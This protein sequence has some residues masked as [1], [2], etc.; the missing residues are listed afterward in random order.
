[1]SSFHTYDVSIQL[2]HSLRPLV[3][4]LRAHDGNLAKQ[5]QRAATSVALNVAEG[6]RRLGGDRT[7]HFAIA[8]GSAREVLAALDVAQA[9][10]YLNSDTLTETR[11]LLDRQLRLLWGLVHGRKAKA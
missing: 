7:H 11:A 10:G 4:K 8:S 5:T 9:W 1:M 2:I 3:A 6:S